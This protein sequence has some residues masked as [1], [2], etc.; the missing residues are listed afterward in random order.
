[1]TLQAFIL[2]GGGPSPCP[3]S[4]LEGSRAVLVDKGLVVWFQGFDIRQLRG[5]GV[6]VKFAGNETRVH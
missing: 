1:M 5:L 2:E 4:P 6:Q 3:R